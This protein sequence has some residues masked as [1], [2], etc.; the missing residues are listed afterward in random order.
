METAT[1]IETPINRYF[2]QHDAGNIT[3]DISGPN[4]PKSL[5]GYNFFETTSDKTMEIYF[6]SA[7]VYDPSNVFVDFESFTFEKMYH[8]SLP[9]SEDI[10]SSVEYAYDESPSRKMD[11]KQYLSKYGLYIFENKANDYRESGNIIWGSTMYHLGF[12]LLES[13]AAAH[14]FTLIKHKQLDQKNEQ[15]AIF[16]G[17]QYCLLY[18]SPSPRD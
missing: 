1:R 13:R 7:Q 15:Q 5:E 3:S 16:T 9:N 2:I 17:Y 18:T 8:A 10:R 4:S 11:Q 12:S 6:E 14:L